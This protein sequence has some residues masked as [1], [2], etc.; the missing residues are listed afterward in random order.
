M[1]KLLS[2]IL[3][4]TALLSYSE[5]KASHAMGADITYTCVGPNRFVITVSFY[6]DCSGIAAPST[7]AL[8]YQS[9]S[10]GTARV[11]RTMRRRACPPAVPPYTACEVS[12]LC[13]A[14]ASRSCCVSSTA[15]C[16]PGVQRYIYDDTITLPSGCTDWKFW[17]SE[18]ARNTSVT[19]LVSPGSQNLR[20]EALVNNVD[21]NCSNGPRFATLP[22]PYICNG[23]LYN[24]SHGAIDADGD[25]LRFVLVNPLGGTA[26]AAT[27]INFLSPFTASNPMSV[28]G[29]FVF[30]STNGQMTFTPNGVQQGVVAI[31]VEEYR[32]GVLVGYVMR[33][34]QIVVLNSSLC[35]TPNPVIAN[36]DSI[37]NGF[38]TDTTTVEI[39]PG[40]ALEFKVRI[41]DPG[42]NN[43][44]V[45]SNLTTSPSPIP[46][47]TFTTAGT[48]D[49]VM[50]T[51]RY[52]A[53]LRDSGC[54]TFAITATN[55]GCPL[56]G[57]NAK[58]FKICVKRDVTV[59]PHYS[60][61]CGD[62]IRINASGGSAS[63]IVW[64]PPAGLSTL[65]GLTT[66]ASP[67]VTTRY[68]F[69]SD[70]G[71]DT[72]LVVVKPFLPVDAG[73]NDTI[74][75]NEEVTL[76]MTHPSVS[77][78]YRYKWTPSLGLSLDTTA[79]T[80]A[81][82][83]VSTQY[84]CTV[85]DRDGCSRTD[86]VWVRASGFAPPMAAF[87]SPDTICPRDTFRLF[88]YSQP[89]I[90]GVNSDPCIGRDSLA[91]I[92]TGTTGIAAVIQG[93]SAS[94]YPSIYG[95]FNKSARHQILYRASDLTRAMGRGGKIESIAWEIGTYYIPS[96]NGTDTLQN[97]TIRMGC[98]NM[99]SLVNWENGLTTVF[100]PKTIRTVSGWN[101]HV[102]DQPYDW[103]GV[104]DII[105]DV[106]FNNPYISGKLNQKFRWHDCGY[107]VLLWNN[108][109]VIQCSAN[110]L[111]TPS[112][113]N[114]FRP[115][116]R[117]TVCMNMLD[118]FLVNW[119]PFSGV[120]AVHH[121][122]RSNTSSTPH[123]NQTYTVTVDNGGC[124]IS[125]TARVIVDTSVT[126]DAVPDTFFLVHLHHQHQL[127]LCK[128]YQK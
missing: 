22:V 81:S 3:C 82:P 56:T 96:T 84:R 45:S 65:V 93:G 89:P 21:T 20:V 127:L 126:L 26:Y 110:S 10:C 9:L 73:L 78:P 80:I 79:S 74:C 23:L 60:V 43:L 33:D 61:Y 47:A 108:N 103:D 8:Y 27:N 25:S 5:V 117:F 88:T 67:L 85:T 2:L 105:V 24:Y 128:Q 83:R 53:G 86:S 28:T 118:S 34:L 55:D 41:W 115:N 64:S 91:S 98:F 69:T 11:T 37:V 71:T 32:D 66:Y 42:N 119:S 95:N 77:P 116:T 104:S 87:G 54:Y 44:T 63:S 4:I 92:I 16:L 30:N 75:L 72:A 58:L 50:A 36:V 19:N 111:K 112:T 101:T 68:T 18:S 51:I 38:A 76:R 106:C 97:F 48:G 59:T 6:R 7:L 99:D 40:A 31:R 109:D 113:D 100:N 107:R 12:P 35:N 102:F 70:C 122:N 62:A 57:N 15:G 17:I 94:Q 123:Y 29:P 124:A 90:C 13:P 14:Y 46:G 39:C 1:K 52:T 49:T 114:N 120:N 125:K 121:P